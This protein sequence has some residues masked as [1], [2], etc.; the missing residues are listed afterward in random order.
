MF[1]RFSKVGFNLHYFKYIWQFSRPHTII[2]TTLNFLAIFFIIIILEGVS[3]ITQINLFWLIIG[4]ITFL[5]GNICIV[6]FNQIIDS[7]LDSINKP[8]LP[9]PAGNLSLIEA[10]LIVLLT[11]ILAITLPFFINFYAILTSFLGLSLG[12]SYSLVKSKKFSIFMV[13]SNLAILGV[14]GVI[15]NLGTFL[16][17][18]ELL[19]LTTID[20]I[21]IFF[22]TTFITISLGSISGVNW[23]RLN[24]HPIVSEKLLVIHVFA[25]PGT[26]S[27]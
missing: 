18:V 17:W 24:S 6:G 11:G 8:W 26:P 15:F 7:D 21:P 1:F 13:F 9:I 3:Q 2:G 14:R 16:T 10:K 19:H 4:L 23:I 22:F 5:S 27:R 25:T 12:L 20:F